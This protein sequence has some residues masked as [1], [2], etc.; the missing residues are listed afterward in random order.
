M[1]LTEIIVVVGVVLFCLF[2]WKRPG[3]GLILLPFGTATVA[4]VSISR[5]NPYI[6]LGEGVLITFAVLS[7]R[8]KPSAS[9]LETPWYRT[10]AIITITVFK[11]LLLLAALTFVFNALGPL[12]F[13]LI[14]VSVVRY[15]MTHRYSLALD[16]L[17]ALGMSVRQSLPLPMAL[18][19]AAQGRKNREAQIFTNISF[20][21]QQGRSLTDALRLGYRSCP[22]ELLASLE[23][24]EGMN[25]LPNAI[26]NLQA[27]ISEKVND[28]K[29][30]RPVYPLYPLIVLVIGFFMV[31]A[32]SIFIVPTFSEVIS[33]I[34]EGRAHLPASTQAMLNFSRFVTANKGM[35]ALLMTLA[36]LLICFYLTAG[37]FRNRNPRR[38]TLHQK[39]K[40][41][42][43]WRLPVFHWFE[44]TYSQLQLTELLRV[45]L[46]AGYPINTALGNALN[47]DM[48]HSFRLQVQNW[49]NRIEQGEP[50]SQAALS[51]GLDRT[52]T[53]AFDEKINKGNTIEVLE[54]L[55]EVYRSRYTHRINM[56]NSIG[57]PL[58]V[59]GLGLGIGWVVYA[60]FMGAFSTLFVT[61]RYT[62]P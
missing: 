40:D 56:L 17:S 53:W 28:Y 5:D 30:I 13:V 8:C 25:Q 58:M 24:A 23:A 6:L 3:G 54:S 16:I 61:I 37:Y 11:Y 45:A 38:P 21:L 43:K 10:V 41:W 31:L 50:V 18:D 48:N 57:T 42:I 34:S 26:E 59:L 60:V 27:D 33:D 19:S 29:R 35:N 12:L 14:A 9:P 55:Q 4:F 36:V 39:T 15:K 20:L 44:R 46:G 1:W 2:S 22:P 7:A 51:S 62:M 32:L 49:L 52:L 47:L